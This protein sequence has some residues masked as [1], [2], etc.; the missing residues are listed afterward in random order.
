[1]FHTLVKSKKYSG[2]YVALKSFRDS[3]VV[4]NGKT[5]KEA[6]KKAQK[7]GCQNPVVIFVPLKDTV[8]IH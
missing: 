4:A 8:F 6:Y 1:M 2:Q 7:N 3:T 5:I